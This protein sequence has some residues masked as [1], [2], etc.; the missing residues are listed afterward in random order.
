MTRSLAQRTAPSAFG[1]CLQ[2][3][4][5]RD[6]HVDVAGFYVGATTRDPSKILQGYALYEGTSESSGFIRRSVYTTRATMG[7][8]TEF[9]GLPVDYRLIDYA[10]TI[11]VEMANPGDRLE[12]VTEQEMIFGRNRFMFGGE[13]IGAAVSTLLSVNDYTGIHTY[14]LS[15]L[16]RGQLSTFSD[17]F[18]SHRPGDLLVRLDDSGIEFFPYAP[19]RVGETAYYKFVPLGG[20]VIESSVTP[21]VLSGA[22]LMPFTP[23]CITGTRN[24]SNDL[25]V[26]WERQSRRSVQSLDQRVPFDSEVE[27]YKIHVLNSPGA[28]TALREV[29]R[30]DTRTWTYT[31]SAQTTDGLTPGNPVHLVISQ[32]GTIL[33][34]GQQTAITL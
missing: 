6:E 15:T 7:T 5:L 31:A 24:G 21:V 17:R 11:T 19:S 23:V 32:M 1:F 16:L 14:T 3:P 26:T 18:M 4:A 25:T 30:V 13:I 29:I 28:A 22:T 20:T 12:S 2:L 34:D 10:N 9:T 33:Q 27:R 8:C